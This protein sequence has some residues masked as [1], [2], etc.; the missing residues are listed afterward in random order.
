MGHEEQSDEIKKFLTQVDTKST[1]QREKMRN[2]VGDKCNQ[3]LRFI[4]DKLN[5]SPQHL[6]YRGSAAVHVYFNTTL[7]QMFFVC[8][9]GPMQDCPEILAIKA[10]EDLQQTMREQYG[11][12]RLVKRSGL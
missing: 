1:V 4:G 6:D 11:R 10:L 2:P 8:Q 12:K 5:P 3:S 7:R 9:T